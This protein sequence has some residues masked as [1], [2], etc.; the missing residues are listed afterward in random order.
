M[1][2]KRFA[3]TW[4]AEERLA[5][6]GLTKSHVEQAVRDGHPLGESNEGEADWRIEARDFVVVY[7]HPDGKDTD[8]VR[9]VSAWRKRHKCRLRTV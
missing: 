1:P 9:V 7:D 8:A 4:H 6:R 2:I 5:E 3:W